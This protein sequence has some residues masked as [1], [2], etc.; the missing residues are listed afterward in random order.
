MCGRRSASFEHFCK[1]READIWSTPFRS[2][3][4]HCIFFTVVSQMGGIMPAAQWWLFLV[5]ANGKVWI[6]LTV[7]L[8]DWSWWQS[9]W[10][11]WSHCTLN[12]E[13]RRDECWSLA[14]FL[15]F[16]QAKAPVHKRCQPHLGWGVPLPVTQSGN[17]FTGTQSFASGWFRIQSKQT[18]TLS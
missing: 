1:T 17:F 18:V 11:D 12:Q 13:E 8:C 15:L 3:H 6:W 5:I 10:G 14:H 2:P 16:I 4:Q 9:P 7:W